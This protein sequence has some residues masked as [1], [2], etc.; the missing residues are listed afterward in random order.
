MAS[1]FPRYRAASTT[2]PTLPLVSTKVDIPY[3]FHHQKLRI[4]K[5]ITFSQSHLPALTELFRRRPNPKN[6][7]MCAN[8]ILIHARRLVRCC[9][10]C[11]K[12]CFFQTDRMVVGWKRDSDTCMCCV[13]LC[14][15]L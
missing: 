6:M 5:S 1:T 9:S 7:I 14:R 4:K 10:P 8:D 13:K 12:S 15:A 3:S 2:A 11:F